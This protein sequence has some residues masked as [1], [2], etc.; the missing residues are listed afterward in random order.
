MS[1]PAN[2]WQ[3]NVSVAVARLTGRARRK[4]SNESFDGG[5]GKNTVCFPTFGNPKKSNE[6][7]ESNEPGRKSNESND[8]NESNEGRGH[9]PNRSVAEGVA[10]TLGQIT[11]ALM[12]VTST[13]T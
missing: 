7:N 9:M 4:T 6:S 5:K 12:N 10:P 8:S 13:L 3:V 1:Q 2:A 11:H